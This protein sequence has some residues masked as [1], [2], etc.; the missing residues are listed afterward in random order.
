MVAAE[1][2]GSE[3]KLEL[4]EEEEEEEEEEQQE[5]EGRVSLRCSALL[6]GELPTGGASANTTKRRASRGRLLQA[7]GRRSACCSRRG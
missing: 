1:T 5:E 6:V 2:E 4:A 3:L 7:R